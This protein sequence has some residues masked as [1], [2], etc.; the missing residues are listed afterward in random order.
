MK[1]F[2]ISV[3]N[4]PGSLA[5]ITETMAKASV[6]IKAIASE[7]RDH[8][9]LVHVVTNDE[10]TTRDAISKAGLECNE[11]EILVLHLIDRAGELSKVARKL[12]DANIN[13]DNIYI[14]GSA[15]GKTDV[16]LAVD[17]MTKARSLLR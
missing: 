5:G 13:V 4:K 16:A 9:G 14:L 10:R 15:N 11:V 7:R 1:Q 2:S 8:S 12:A 3:Q 6:N 17:N